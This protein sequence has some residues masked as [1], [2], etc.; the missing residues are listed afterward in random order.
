M[1]RFKPAERTYQ[2]PMQGWWMKN[3]YFLRYM[4]REA[5]AL[6]LTGYALMLLLGLYR[7]SQGAAA[8]DAWRALLAT[9]L[10]IALHGLAL[11]FA[12]YHSLTWFQVMP[13]TAP[14]LPLGPR[15][16]TAA[17]IGAALVLSLTIFG[18]LRWGL[19]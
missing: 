1:N 10:S 8:Y 16:I 11:L 15:A 6:F 18:A 9:P 12:A 5:S 13:K 7:L 14:R 3:P 2:R 4:L 17:G 19:R